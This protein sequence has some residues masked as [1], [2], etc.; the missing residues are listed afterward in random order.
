[1]TPTLKRIGIGAGAAVLVL[2][3]VVVAMF[4]F[5]TPT[6]LQAPP[7]AAS[8]GIAA[9]RDDESPMAVPLD[10]APTQDPDPLAVQIPGCVCHSDDP[11]VV[12]EHASYRMSQ[13]FDCH[14]DGMPE[15]DQ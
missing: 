7:T 14:S 4:A 13:C 9:P 2:A 5:G 12:E 10:P 15:M 6:T 8:A 11:A 1:M 3:A